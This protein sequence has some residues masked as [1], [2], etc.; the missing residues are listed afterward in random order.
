MTDSATGS[1]QPTDAVGRL[2]YYTAISLAILG[3]VLIC[4]IATIVTVSVA[5]RYLFN[6]P[7]PGDYDIVGIMSG[8]AVFAFLPYCQLMRGN[9][10]VDFF[11]DAAP[12]RVKA[13]LDAMGSLMYLVVAIV[14]TWRLY[15]GALDLHRD[16]EVI[17]AFRF[18]RWWTLPFDIFC[19]GVL[20]LIVAYV[21]ARDIGAYFGRH[22]PDK[23]FTGGE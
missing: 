6:S 17:A 5:G 12:V 9:V 21:F 11:T 14:F 4:A 3:G 20:I 13:L 18:Y 8:C 10:V 2:L 23:A 15:L 1:Q 7:I 22:A 19:M 16:G